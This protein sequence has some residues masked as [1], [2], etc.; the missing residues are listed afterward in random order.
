MI[1]FNRINGDTV[2]INPDKIIMI[3]ASTADNSCV[4]ISTTDGYI[5]VYIEESVTV[6]YSKIESKRNR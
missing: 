5:T 1:L 2:A 6:A 3:Q 4:Y